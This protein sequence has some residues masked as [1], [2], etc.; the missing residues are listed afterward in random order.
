VKCSNVENVGLLDCD[1]KIDY[2]V[3]MLTL[4]I[5]HV[6]DDVIHEKIDGVMHEIDE[7]TI[8][9]GKEAELETFIEDDL[10]K[11]KMQWI[12]NRIHTMELMKI[13]RLQTCLLS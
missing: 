13:R 10:F 4:A 11:Q 5:E 6:I 3:K 12:G 7:D 2:D 1:N 8:I 9:T